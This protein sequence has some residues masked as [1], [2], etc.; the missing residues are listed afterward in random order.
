M[1]TD[2]VPKNILEAD[3]LTHLGHQLIE[4]KP[5]EGVDCYKRAAILGSKESQ[6]HLAQCYENGVGI[7]KDSKQAAYWMSIAGH[8]GH[9]GA[10]L[11]MGNTYEGKDGGEK[12]LQLALVWYQKAYT[13]GLDSAK[14]DAVRVSEKIRLLKLQEKRLLRNWESKLKKI[15]MED[16]E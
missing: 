16:M 4:G 12:N 10:C 3:K 1:K 15:R 13:F 11:W 14:D 2:V 7:L 9:A 8:S 6:Y 5:E